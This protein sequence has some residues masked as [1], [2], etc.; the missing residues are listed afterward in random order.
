MIFQNWF[1]N[2]FK[3]KPK[4]DRYFYFNHQDNHYNNSN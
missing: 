2:A 1:E 3:F 4:L